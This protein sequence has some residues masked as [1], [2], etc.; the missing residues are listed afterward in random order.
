M[1]DYEPAYTAFYPFLLSGK[2][3]SYSEEVGKINFKRLEAVS[4]L[5]T[6]HI[7]PKDTEIRQIAVTEKSKIFK[8]YFLANQYVQSSLQ[9]SA[10]NED[11]V[12][13]VLDENQ[14]YMDE[15]VL[16]G[17]G[18]SVATVVN[19]GLYWSGD[20][21]YVLETSTVIA[22]AS[23]WL[24]D[25][26]AKVVASKIKADL[27]AGPKTIVFYGAEMIPVI[28]SLYASTSMPF[29][30]ALSQVLGPQYTI[31]E[32]QAEITPASA[33]GWM[34]VNRAQTKLH[35]TTLPVLKA[36]GINDEK[37]YSWHNFLMGSAMVE[38]LA[39]KGII[40]QPVTFGV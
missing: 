34:I 22:A 1:G 11:I 6:K 12:K 24:P 5:R 33:N 14:K 3:Q 29:K 30:T 38:V 37:M 32:L 9:D 7:T 2:S 26:H 35:Y 27:V 17:E 28:N 18:T 25:L 16:L 20:S 23:G 36:Q 31:A 13:Q 21:N 8:K 40:R 19:N 10:Q 4:D 39:P 15:I